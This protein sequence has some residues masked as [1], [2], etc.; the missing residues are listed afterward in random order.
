MRCNDWIHLGDAVFD[1]DRV[2]FADI[3]AV[4]E[5][6]A[7]KCT[8][9]SPE[10]SPFADAQCGVPVYSYRSCVCLHVPWQ[11]MFATKGTTVPASTPSAV[12]IAV[13]VS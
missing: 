2:E 8:G 6:E 13:A 4:A 3:D 12:A 9:I 10:K 11:K 1:V 5:T 7:P